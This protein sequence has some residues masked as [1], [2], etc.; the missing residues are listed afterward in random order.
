MQ[1]RQGPP[2]SLAYLSNQ[3]RDAVG[4]VVFDDEIRNY[5][6][7]SSRQ[8]QFARM[9]HAIE[10]ATPGTRTD[11]AKPFF[12]C[13]NFLHRRG[14]L[15]VISDF[16]EQPELVIKTLEPMRAHGNELILFHVLDPQEIRPSLREPVLMVDMETQAEVE[17]SPDYVRGEYTEKID[18]HIEAM[19]DRARR[20]GIDYALLDTSKPLDAAL[21]EYLIIRQG[22]A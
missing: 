22:R 9:L 5:I 17:V 10:N 21:R 2:A 19:R 1:P 4:M 16:Y 18:A 13:M 8:G 15:V 12:H 11:F 20:A 14:I 6:P 7:P 3:Q